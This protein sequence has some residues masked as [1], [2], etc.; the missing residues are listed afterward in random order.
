M[1]GMQQIITAGV[2]AV[3]LTPVMV[4]ANKTPIKDNGQC[5]WLIDGYNVHHPH[6][7]RDKRSSKTVQ[8]VQPFELTS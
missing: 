1:I 3:R 7:L 5:V 8:T 6:W 4:H 2:S